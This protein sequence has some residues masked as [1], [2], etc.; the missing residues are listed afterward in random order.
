[1]TILNLGTYPPKQCGIATFSMD[2]R[3][4]LLLLG[5]EVQVM[6]VSDDEYAYRYPEEVVFNLRQLQKQDYVKAANFINKSRQIELIIVQHEY[7]IYGGENGEYIR[8]FVKL[9]HRPFVLVTHTVLPCPSKRQKQ[10]LNDL[11]HRAAGI[12]C[13]TKKSAQ[14]LI[15]L[16]E[17]PSE[18]IKVIAHGVPEFKPYPQDNLKAKHELKGCDIISTFGLIGPGKGLE[19]GIRAVADLVPCH[20]SLRYLILGQTHPMLQKHEGEKYRQMLMELVAEL[21]IQDQVIFINKYLTDEELGEYLYMTDIY[22]SPYPNKDQAVSG[23]MAFAMGCGRAIVSTP[24]AYASEVLQEKR[25]LIT[26]DVSSQELAALMRIIL[27]DGELKHN[28][29]ENAFKVGKTWRWPNVGQQY[30]DFFKKILHESDSDESR[31]NYAKL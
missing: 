4:S 2:L 21:A 11:C 14:L 29:Q 31:F 6:T 7:G 17:A 15:D 26:K 12:V 1:M 22:L 25:G 24:Y 3:N 30:S 5:H 10:I 16:Y 13:M 8:Q 27:Q 18:L 28:L 9:L 23:T 19:L 20:P